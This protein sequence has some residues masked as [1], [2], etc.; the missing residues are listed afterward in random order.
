[1]NILI[2]SRNSFLYSTRS[3]MQAAFRKG[4]L[5]KV[6]DHLSCDLYIQ[7][8]GLRTYTNGFEIFGYDAVIPRIGSSVT[9]YGVSVIRHLSMQG[10]FSTLDSEALLRARDKFFCLQLL[11]SAGLPVP[12]TLLVNFLEFN[13]TL[14][15]EEFDQQTVVKMLESTHGIGVI[16]SESHDNAQQIIESFYKMKEKAIIQE[17]IKEAKGEDIRAF[18]VDGEVV[19]S[20][21]RVAQ[22]GEFR[23]NLHRGASAIPIKLSAEEEE[24]AVRATEVLG[25][26]VAGVDLLR[27]KDGVLIIEVN[28]SPGLEGI[29]TST[30]I[31]VAGKIISYI[32][33]NV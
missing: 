20:M 27:S 6:V 24:V 2:L 1:M 25:L 26:K 9:S 7:N 12:K 3:L 19:A 29:E 33:R 13:R 11:A 14:L 5:V 30:G 31:D 23:S 17:F 18:V 22:S 15:S 10:L 28:A 16:L 32:E 4:H 21:N 8:D